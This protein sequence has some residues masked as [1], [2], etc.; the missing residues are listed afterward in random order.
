MHTFTTWLVARW[1]ASGPRPHL[2]Q[3]LLHL[4]HSALRRLGLLLNL[5]KGPGD[6]LYQQK[7]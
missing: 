5:A 4:V 1:I 2:V 3:H 7:I 6:T